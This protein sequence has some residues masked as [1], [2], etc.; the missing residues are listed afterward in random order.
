MQS[1][2]RKIFSK[3]T[4]HRSLRFYNHKKFNK[5]EKVSQEFCH[6]VPKV[7]LHAHLHGCIRPSTLQEYLIDKEVKYNSEDFHTKDMKG[8]FRMFDNI[9]AAIDNLKQVKRVAQEM[10]FDFQAQNCH[11]LELRSTPRALGNDTINNYIETLLEEI[12]RFEQKQSQMK[13]RLLVSMSRGEPLEN[14]KETLALAKRYKNSGYILGVDYSGNPFQKSFSMF[15][16]YF[17]EA[18]KAGL[19]TVVHCAELPDEK[20]LG[21]TYDVLEFKPDR[22][23]HFNYYNQELFEK[24]LKLGIPIEMCPTSNLF[25]MGLKDYNEHHFIKF[26]YKGHPFALCTDDTA[27]FDTNITEEYLRIF[28][29]Y[30]FDLEMAKEV[31]KNSYKC[32]F[33]EK[34]KKDLGDIIL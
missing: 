17:E 13:I 31:I 8:A 1:L 6:E 18:R 19:K 24:I 26:F 33:D 9:H 14:A 32:V 25:T 28:N 20:T 27:V 7:E 4:F 12:I 16:P 11:Y 2:T 3:S 5:K 21:E 23:G 15:K 30:D 34:I 22:V 10:F 29:S